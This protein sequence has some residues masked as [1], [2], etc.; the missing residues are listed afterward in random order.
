M[1]KWSMKGRSLQS[2]S[3]GSLGVDGK[4][5]LVHN[6]DE[7][8][9]DSGE[10]GSNGDVP[11]LDGSPC[12]G[13]HQSSA[14]SG[15]VT[16]LGGGGGGLG[17][18]GGHKHAARTVSAVLGIG[19]E[20]TNDSNEDEEGNDDGDHNDGGEQ[21]SNKTGDG[22]SGGEDEL[23]ADTVKEEGEQEGQNHESSKEGNEDK[24]LGGLDNV[25]DVGGQ[26]VV[27]VGGLKGRSANSGVNSLH[28]SEIVVNFGVRL[29][30]RG[31]SKGNSGSGGG[32]G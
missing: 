9:D 12:L 22:H 25:A 14:G 27:V 24:S 7:E 32:G 23:V 18:G 31:G 19:S 11:S 5:K 10:G 8:E 16:V 2:L 4:R 17:G 20:G 13:V 15:S 30:G 1:V 28:S 3:R 29:G 21:H 26:A 6:D